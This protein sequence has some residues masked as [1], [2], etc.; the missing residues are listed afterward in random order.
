ML[1]GCK[2]AALVWHRRAGK[3]TSVFNWV[4]AASQIRV[5]TYY[6][7]FPTFQQGRRVLWEGRNREGL[8]FLDHIPPEMIASK[9]E[10][11]M[12]ISFVNGSAVQIVGTDNY[13]SIRGTNPVGCVFSEYASQNPNAFEVV[14]PILRENGGWAV[15]VYT[16]LGRNHGYKLYETA[17]RNSE[18]YTSLLTIR[19]TSVFSQTDIDA[20]RAAG[21]DEEYIQQEYYCSF[22]G[23]VE[24]SFYAK[25]L[26]TAYEQ[27]R[28]GRFPYDPARPV[29]TGFD[30]GT[31]RDPTAVWFYQ[32]QGRRVTFIDYYE[33]NETNLVEI[34][35]M[36]RTKGYLY[37]PGLPHIAPHDVKR[38]EW[39]SGNSAFEIAWGMGVRFR[40]VP[41]MNPLERVAVGRVLFPRCYFDEETCRLGLA[42]LAQ[43][44]KERDEHGSTPGRPAYKP[45][46]AHDWSSHGADAFGHVAVGIENPP[47]DFRPTRAVVGFDP[48]TYEQDRYVD[49]QH[50]TEFN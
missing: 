44:H 23:S 12:R 25:Q 40:V 46:A 27:G 6:Y 2:Y 13:D 5:G 26:R 3:D 50:A 14:A 1:G 19:D 30:I 32:Q 42:S 20:E 45:R 4:I 31:T 47:E 41:K 7:F 22:S 21:R 34:A 11:D 18:W 10:T 37:A 38:T 15:F 8:R 16:P 39:G 24:G 17:R 36:L 9:N 49:P 29:E 43:Y 33:A 48:F 35:G 28:V